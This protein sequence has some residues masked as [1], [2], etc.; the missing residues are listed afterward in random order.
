MCLSFAESAHHNLRGTLASLD[1]VVAPLD[2]LETV[3]VCLKQDLKQNPIKFQQIYSIQKGK[4]ELPITAI[5]VLFILKRFK[6]LL[7]NVLQNTKIHQ[8]LL[9][10]WLLI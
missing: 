8:I 10:F 6:V 1:S 7:G 9:F 5:F 3:L 2:S 4:R